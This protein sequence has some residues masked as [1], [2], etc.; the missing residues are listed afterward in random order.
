MLEKQAFIEA[1]FARRAGGFGSLVPNQPPFSYNAAP[2]MI[3]RVLTRNGEPM[4]YVPVG[5]K[6]TS[7]G[8]LAVVEELSPESRMEV[9]VA[10]PVGLESSL[11]VDA[12]FMEIA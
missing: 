4:R 11:L 3:Y 5:P 6:R 2:R 7:H 10:A 12:G 9:P 1:P 8:P